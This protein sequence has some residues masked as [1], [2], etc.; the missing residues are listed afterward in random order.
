MSRPRVDP[1]VRFAR[2]CAAQDNGC[3]LWTGQLDKHG[4]A[5]FWDGR[6]KMFGHV[7]AYEQAH[8]PVPPGLVLDHFRCDTPACVEPTHCRPVTQR[9]NVLRGNGFAAAHAAKTRCVN[10]HEF[11]PENTQITPAGTRD[12]RAC[13]ASRERA[14]RR[15]LA[16]V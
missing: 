8:G 6:R 11:T 16:S 1:A 10:G 13:K 12:C 4:Y 9:E 7:W 3:V 2:Y 5:R 15:R 14:R